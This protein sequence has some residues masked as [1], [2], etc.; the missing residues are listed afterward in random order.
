MGRGE[1]IDIPCEQAM[2]KY[3]KDFAE[4]D[5]QGS[6]LHHLG[7]Q[8]KKEDKGLLTGSRQYDQV[9]EQVKQLEHSHAESRKSP[10]VQSIQQTLEEYQKTLQAA[11]AYLE[12]KHNAFEEKIKGKSEK[13]QKKEL[14]KYQDPNSRDFK[15]RAAVSELIG[16]LERFQ[17][18]AET[19]LKS[20]AQYEEIKAIK[21]GGIEKRNEYLKKLEGEKTKEQAGKASAKR[22]LMSKDELF[23]EFAGKQKSAP[24]RVREKE[25]K[26]PEKTFSQTSRSK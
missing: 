10:S 9:M 19:I 5:R 18:Q 7:S 3:L 25:I 12:Y 13:E 6:E 24:D 21:D 15:R 11:Q 22:V 16:K 20:R 23:G 26:A 1:L 8:L 2:G 14:K 4:Y 17:K